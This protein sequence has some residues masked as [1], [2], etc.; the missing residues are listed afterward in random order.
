MA[1]NSPFRTLEV[2]ASALTAE[3]ARFAVV[4]RNLA[5]ANTL[6]ADPG[7]E[8]YRRQVVLFETVLKEARG[9]AEPVGGVR[10]RRVVADDGP[11]PQILKVG[12]PAADAQGYVRAPN[13][14][15]AT[16]MVDLMTAVQ[17]YEAN[18]TALRTFREMLQRTFEIV[19]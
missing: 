11:F 13:V 16:E 12:H 18:L 8:P 9:L 17:S 4:A 2:S 7:A 1:E 14:D 15:V 3:R 19:R 6:P 10:L 5:N